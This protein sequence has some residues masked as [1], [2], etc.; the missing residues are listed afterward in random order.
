MALIQA[1]VVFLQLLAASNAINNTLNPSCKSK[2]G[3]VE[4]PYP[5]GIGEGC[6]M[7]EHGDFR[8]FC[9]ESS[10]PP[11]PT[12]PSNPPLEITKIDLLEGFLH[13]KVP[14]SYQCVS[15]TGETTTKIFNYDFTGLPYSISLFGNLFTVVGCDTLGVL[16][17]DGGSFGC[18]ASC[19]KSTQQPET[20]CDGLGCCR[21]RIP[22]TLGRIS[23]SI[24][25]LSNYSQFTGLSRC[26]AAFFMDGDSYDL[27]ES[28]LLNTTTVA[29]KDM[30]VRLEWSV[31][32]KTCEKSRRKSACGS[33]YSQC[34]DSFRRAGYLCRCAV[35]FSGNAYI[36]GGCS[37][38]STNSDRTYVRTSFLGLENMYPIWRIIGVSVLGLLLILSCAIFFLVHQRRKI[39]KQRK[40][41]AELK[42][43]LFKQ[44]GGVALQELISSTPGSAFKIFSEAELVRATQ[45]FKETHVLGRGGHGV[46]FK[47]E[48]DS[49][50][51]VAIKK[52]RA[53]NER[54]SKEFARE[55]A[56]L[57]QINHV[58]VVKILGC[59]LD[60]EI[61][62]LVYEFIPGGTLFRFIHGSGDGLSSTGKAEN[63]LSALLRIAREVAEA[64]AYLHSYASPPI[65]HKDVKTSNVL[66]DGSLRAKIADFGA[67]AVVAADQAEV[68]TVVQGTCGYL[69]PEY[70]QTFQFTEKSDVY[71]FGVVLVEMITRR[72][73]FQVE[74]E[75]DF[76]GLAASF[77][78][79]Q[80]SGR[81]DEM[82]DPLLVGE[83]EKK[84]KIAE[85]AELACR[86][87][88]ARGV[89]RPS[90][91]QVA[92]ALQ[93]IEG[94]GDEISGL[95]CDSLQEEEESLRS[96]GI[97]A[98]GIIDCNASSSGY[99]GATVCTSLV[100]R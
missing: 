12:I 64:L 43:K 95:V 41:A 33:L 14:V 60:V 23:V 75:D 80:R 17:F 44:N 84:K 22:D 54:E 81:L 85:V 30:T 39:V 26:G 35:G 65:F 7:Q 92:V 70:L 37:A 45:G 48:L 57:S 62:M 83:T 100:A 97:S 47:G 72:K 38:I 9:N 42:A 66:L 24:S 15:E 29:A 69:D 89:E 6:H 1:L 19:T 61:P 49:G 59:C 99:S 32:D 88:N 77:S 40:R 78:A 25:S 79:R 2:C 13:V 63:A 71:S 18:L 76:K 21:V 86:C 96:G 27:G 74:D 36:E 82:L 46:V 20:G 94:S 3:N 34:S 50:L 28:I 51:T 11:K 10:S 98:Q 31:D 52:S 5:F 58:N 68:A 4:I 91:K 8:V 16:N 90:M 55:M 53:M 93:R 67:S 73:P 56:I 87:L